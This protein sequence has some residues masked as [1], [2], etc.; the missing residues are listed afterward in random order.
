MAKLESKCADKF[1]CSRVDEL[2][3]EVRGCCQGKRPREQDRVA[4]HYG[5]EAR[6]PTNPRDFR[7]SSNY[8]IA[9]PLGRRIPTHSSIRMTYARTGR[10]CRPAADRG[11]RLGHADKAEDK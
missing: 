2:N 6:S 5:Q 4:G 8:F 3:T 7:Q 1:R 9:S 11:P 10:G